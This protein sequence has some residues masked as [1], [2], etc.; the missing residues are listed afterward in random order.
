MGFR[1]RGRINA[2]IA[3]T[4][5]RFLVWRV[6]TVKQQGNLFR[7]RALRR[8]Y[9]LPEIDIKE[10][11]SRPVTLPELIMD[12]IGMPPYVETIEHDDIRPL[13]TIAAGLQ[14]RV[15]VELGTA[16]G[17]STANLCKVCPDATI[18]TVNA[19][20]EEQ[21]GEL[22]TFELTREQVGRVY[23]KAGYGDRVV[24]IFKN[25]LE[26]DLSEYLPQPMV[27]LAII[28]ACHD[29]DFVIN[30]FHKVKSFIKPGGVVVFHDTHPSLWR[31]TFGSYIACMKLRQQGFDI[32]HLRSTWWGV[33]KNSE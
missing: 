18:Y 21:S 5:N 13:L 17:N 30:D 29:T 1:I 27:D 22:V 2:W 28:D 9:A 6:D 10:I 19:P 4:R 12:D 15:I 16:Y 3:H 32:R 26:L 11:A 8:R 14:S 33:W 25:T 20:A 7:T 31:H 24:Q 23:R